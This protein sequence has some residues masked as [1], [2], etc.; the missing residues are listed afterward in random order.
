M[1]V[2]PFDDHVRGGGNKGKGAALGVGL[3][4]PDGDRDVVRYLKIGHGD[5]AH[6]LQKGGRGPIVA[7]EGISSDLQARELLQKADEVNSD[8]E[9]V[10]FCVRE[11]TWPSVR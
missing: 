9:P 8:D 11:R 3:G 1:S 4:E 10:A 6:G 5:G 7:C 2:R